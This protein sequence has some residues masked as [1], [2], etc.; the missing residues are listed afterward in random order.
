MSQLAEPLR[1][2]L[3]KDNT[4]SW[5]EEHEKSFCKV[6]E[7]LS[8]PPILA[9]YDPQLPVVLQ[10]DA[11]RLKGLGYACLQRHEDEWKLIECGSRFLTETESRYATIELEMLAIVWAVKKC[12]KYL[13]GRK[14]F[15]VITDHKPLV[16]I[17]NTKG[18]CDIENP[19]LQRLREN[20]L[21]YSFTVEW[22]KGSEHAIPD[23]LSRCP[24]ENA[25]KDD[26]IAEQE[27]EQHI[28]AIIASNIKAVNDEDK[29]QMQDAL[30][31]EVHKRSIEDPEYILLKETIIKGFPA[32]QNELDPCLRPYSKM[33][34]LLC[35]DSDLIVCGQR[36]VIPYKLRKDVLRRLHSS[37]QGIDRT[38][39]SVYWP[40]IDNDI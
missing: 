2:L 23:A 32:N 4:W 12:K 13:I 36:L 27:V 15:D 39:Q 8:K 34:E 38:R 21:P 29:D 30:L 35:V 11:A 37:H 1:H 19:R 10:T 24:V 33:K 20:L 3:K 6:K 26:E 9:Y 5:S 18:L 40:G 16:P 31:E 22:K 14:H 25:T 28:H 7:A 17:I